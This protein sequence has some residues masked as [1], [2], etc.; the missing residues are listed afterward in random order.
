MDP[1][2]PCRLPMTRRLAIDE[3]SK[4]KRWGVALN[5]HCVRQPRRDPSC[6]ASG[7]L[8]GPHGRHSV[9]EHGLDARARNIETKLIMK[10]E[11]D[12]VAPVL[13]DFDCID[14][15]FKHR[16]RWRPRLINSLAP[17]QNS[18]PSLHVGRNTSTESRRELAQKWA[19]IQT[20]ISAADC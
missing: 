19:Q 13:I 9:S 6:P 4:P 7:L 10:R 5:N 2:R 20:Q 15:H 3:D 8:A 11:L 14:R 12:G 16:V 1:R 18:C 17:K